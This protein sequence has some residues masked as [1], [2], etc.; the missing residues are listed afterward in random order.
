MERRDA[1]AR[2]IPEEP[3]VMRIVLGVVESV[4]RSVAEGVKR[5]M[6]ANRLVLD[7]WCEGGNGRLG[8][9]SFTMKTLVKRE[10]VRSFLKVER[11]SF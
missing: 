2:P 6:L 3:P 4:W 9:N 11:N 7:G 10:I 5:V 8:D 1:V